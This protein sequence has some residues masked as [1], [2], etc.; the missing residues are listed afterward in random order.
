[1]KTYDLFKRKI[2]KY[3][4]I[5]FGMKIKYKKINM[6]QNESYISQGRKKVSDTFPSTHVS[7][8]KISFITKAG[9]VHYAVQYVTR[10]VQA[11]YK[12]LK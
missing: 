7:K 12:W 2:L 9:T 11:D 3:I 5:L 4:I 6:F 10:R 8:R 1:M